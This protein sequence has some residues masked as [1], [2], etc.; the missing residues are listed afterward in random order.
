MKIC[1][2][3]F[4]SFCFISQFLI[5]HSSLAQAGEKADCK[6]IKT[7]RFLI[8]DPKTDHKSEI[9]RKK[10]T[11]IEKNLKTGEINIFSI[12]WL[13]DCDYELRILKGSDELMQ[14]FKGKTLTVRTLKQE[15]EMYFFSASMEGFPTLEFKMEKMD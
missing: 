9:I 11:Q 8:N 5:C 3:I 4:L 1:L 7:G 14:F 2:K 12:K 10:K 6:N 13:T 15:G